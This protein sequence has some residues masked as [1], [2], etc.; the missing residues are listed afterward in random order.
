VANPRLRPEHAVTF[1][2]DAERRLAKNWHGQISVYRYRLD[3]LIEA[4]PTTGLLQYQNDERTSANGME[5]ELS[6]KWLRKIETTVSLA[7]QRAT[8]TAS[9]VYLTNS[10]GSVGKFRGSIP[11]FRD[12]LRVAGAAQ[13]LSAR[14][15]LSQAEVPP[16]WLA[17]LT[18]TTHALLPDFDIQFGV[19]NLF[20]RAY[21][22]PVG[23]GL[24]QDRLRQDGRAVFLKL[25]WRTRE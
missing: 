15:T 8:D 3:D 9:R 23:I 10:P 11:L 2:V 4:E 20:N 7:I 16:Y 1:E 22:D 6:G 14:R 5:L 13:Y 12:R 21:F 18:L 25:V 17:D 24:I 19:R